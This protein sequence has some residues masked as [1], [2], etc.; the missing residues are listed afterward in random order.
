M[1][2]EE[3]ISHAPTRS[4]AEDIQRLRSNLRHKDQK[5][6]ALTTATSKSARK[7]IAM[8]ARAKAACQMA[9]SEVQSISEQESR[10]DLAQD[11]TQ[12]NRLICRSSAVSWYKSRSRKLN[13]SKTP[14]ETAPTAVLSRGSGS[15]RKLHQAIAH[16]TISGLSKR[17]S[18]IQRDSSVKEMKWLLIAL[19]S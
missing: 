17:I 14:L 9:L 4:I 5:S 16:P 11:L 1:P 12:L 19:K 18:L 2:T 6:S 7:R 3:Y 13:T 8:G 15:L 10:P